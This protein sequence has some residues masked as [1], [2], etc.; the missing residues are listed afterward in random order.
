MIEINKNNIKFN[1]KDNEINNMKNLYLYTHTQFG[2]HCICYGLVK[3]LSKKYYR[4]FLFTKKAFKNKDGSWNT[5]N[6]HIENVKRLYST[7][8][9][10]IVI[11]DNPKDYDN[12]MVIG[13]DKFFNDVKSG[14]PVVFD[15]YFYEQ[16]NIP[17]NLKWDNFYIK[18]DLEKEKDIFYNILK[19]K[20][21]EPFIFLQ[22][23]STRKY[24]IDRKYANTNIKVLETSKMLDVSIMDLTYTIEKANEVHVINSSFLNFIDLAG[25]KNTNLFYH[26]YTRPKPYEQPSLRLPWKIIE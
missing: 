24:I 17:F 4:V 6:I 12:V 10:V 9:N 26:K 20:D 22:E 15:K 16:A 2:D 25:I 7:I 5:R 1:V 14:K 13:W 21:N 3:E 11:T 18:R 19:L 8:K 23:D